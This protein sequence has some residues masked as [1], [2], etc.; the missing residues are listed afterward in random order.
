[1]KLERNHYGLSGLSKAFDKV[2][3][4]GLLHKLKSNA[5]EGNLLKWLEDYLYDRRI[6]VV[7]NGQCAPWATTNAGAPQGSILGPLLFLV[8]IKDVVND[9]DSDINLFADNI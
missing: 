2:W 4:K 1:M 5:I 3:H 9:I 6:R 8:F 7:I